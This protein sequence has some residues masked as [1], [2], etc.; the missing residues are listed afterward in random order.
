MATQFNRPPL[1]KITDFKSKLTGGGAR[2]NLFEV[3]LAFPDS[4]NIDNDVKDKSRFL[5]KSAA[6]P[7]SNITPIDINFIG[8]ILK[9]A[10]DR[11]FDTWTITVINDTDFAIRS[12]FEKWMNVINKLSDATGFNDPAEYQEDAFVHQLD[13]DGS[14][15]RTYKF[16]DI[17]PTNISQ[18]DLSYE[19]IDTVEEFTVELQVLY[20]ESL[21]GVGANAGGESIS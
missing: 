16:F 11:T 3:E 14:T 1:R 19:T 20:W 17:F 15:L 21:K 2:P 9:I 18:M 5:V 12:A 13:R 10:G 6:L 4:I 8:R 7:A